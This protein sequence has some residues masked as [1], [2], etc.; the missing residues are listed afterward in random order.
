MTDVT[1][2]AGCVPAILPKQCIKSLVEGLPRWLSLFQRQHLINLAPVGA[3]L[4]SH[5]Q[6]GAQNFYFRH[7]HLDIENGGHVGSRLRESRGIHQVWGLIN[8][9][10]TRS[11]KIQFDRQA[12]LLY[13][14][15]F[16]QLQI[17]LSAN[18]VVQSC[19]HTKSTFPEIKKGY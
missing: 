19:W 15:M 16:F 9:T 2:S 1:Q 18:L 14:M 11:F 7:R 8:Q 13:F 10:K 3:I 12:H 5:R 6:L 4:N 17:P